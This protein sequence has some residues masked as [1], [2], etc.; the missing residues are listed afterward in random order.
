MSPLLSSRMWRRIGYATVLGV[1]PLLLTVTSA[2][3]ASAHGSPP[4][5]GAERAVYDVELATTGNASHTAP[6]TAGGAT[7]LAAG[8]TVVAHTCRRVPRRHRG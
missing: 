7:V 3:S 1:G 4:Q 5:G 8:A 2:T 6:L